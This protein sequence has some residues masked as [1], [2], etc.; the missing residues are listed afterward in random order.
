VT[1][2]NGTVLTGLA[3]LSSSPAPPSRGSNQFVKPLTIGGATTTLL[4]D[5]AVTAAPCS[6]VT[7]FRRTAC[8]SSPSST[9]R[10]RR[11]HRQ[12]DDSPR[13]RPTAALVCARAERRERR[14]QS[15]FQRRIV[16]PASPPRRQLSRGTGRTTTN[17]A[18][19]ARRRQQLP[20][21]RS[22]VARPQFRHARQHVFGDLR[23]GGLPRV[24][25]DR[26]RDGNRCLRNPI[27][28]VLATATVSGA[29]SGTAAFVVYRPAPS[30]SSHVHRLAD[31]AAA[32][33][34]RADAHR[35]H[36]LH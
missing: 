27:A 17:F 33:R 18:E 23:P 30:R 8:S 19:D 14:W 7:R 4:V 20:S 12:R 25:R 16:V 3:T 21:S 28:A 15:R 5:F 22:A 9:A 1:L 29:V 13:Q 36:E 2:K 24:Q 11:G 31:S 35:R 26:W 32:R 34:R 10:R 6:A